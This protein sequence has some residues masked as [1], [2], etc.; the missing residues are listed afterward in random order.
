[1]VLSCAYHRKMA[2][3]VKEY[4]RA[5]QSSP[6]RRWSDG[7]D[8]QAA[9]QVAKAIVRMKQGNTSNIKPQGG[10][11][12]YVIDW[13]PGYRIYLAQEG[14]TIIILFG[15]GTKKR[16]QADINKARLLYQEYKQRK[17]A[18]GPP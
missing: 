10:I 4:I 1:M 15:G 8:T 5:D 16:Q 18:G 9:G 14:A 13:G 6:F 7:L 3:I 2:I 17:K 11:S 12:E